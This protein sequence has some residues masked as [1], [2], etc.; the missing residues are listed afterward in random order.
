MQTLK[1]FAIIDWRPDQPN[2]MP[3]VTSQQGDFAITVEKDPEGRPKALVV[4]G[5][6]HFGPNTMI[7][8]CTSQAPDDVFGYRL[9]DGT[10]FIE[11]MPKCE[12]LESTQL[13]IEVPLPVV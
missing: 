10:A 8:V 7:R 13:Q 12:Y 4:R 5:T 3:K 2:E 1:C 9:D 11:I 6:V